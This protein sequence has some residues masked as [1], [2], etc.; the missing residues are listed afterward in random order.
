MMKTIA[1]GLLVCLAVLLFFSGPLRAGD[2][3]RIRRIRVIDNP[4]PGR[5]EGDEV[6]AVTFRILRPGWANDIGWSLRCY[7]GEKNR[8]GTATTAYFL[9]S[10]TPRRLLRG[11]RL[12]GDNTFT[13]FFPLRPS[14]VY[15]VIVLGN[16]EEQEAVLFPYLSL[17]QDFNVGEEEVLREIESSGYC[18]VPDDVCR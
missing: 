1:K 14:A 10:D 15:T 18:L 17:L 11:R 12:K 3:F 5:I 2:L 16:Q 6:M 7:D 9:E 8:L 4:V 13:A